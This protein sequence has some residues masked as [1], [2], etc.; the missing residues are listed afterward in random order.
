MSVSGRFVR[1]VWSAGTAPI[2]SPVATE[3]PNVKA[4][5]TASMRMSAA[6]GMLGTIATSDRT[7]QY[8]M[9]RPRMLPASDSM[10]LSVRSCLMS[11]QR[12][13]PNA[14]RIATSFCRDVTRARSRLATL[15]QAIS[16]TKPTAPRRT[17]S[18]GRML[19]VDSS[20][21][22][23]T[24]SVHF[25]PTAFGYRRRICSANDF[26]SASACFTD[27]PGLRLAVKLRY[28]FV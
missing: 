8:A 11:T 16:R 10:T 12:S 20:S 28:S 15:A 22:D 7:L 19:P 6:R 25:V 24:T 23:F 21:S 5:T 26:I 3:M 13:A 2:N 17:S 18:A 27:T 9:P 14:V 1:D 4:I